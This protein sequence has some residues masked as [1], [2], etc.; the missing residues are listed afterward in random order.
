MKNNVRL[1]KGVAPF[2]VDKMRETRL[3]LFEHVKRKCT[4]TPVKRCMRQISRVG[5]KRGR[6]RP[7]K[8]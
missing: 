3:I 8:Y 1:G 7:K 2:V 5:L 4:N 6:G